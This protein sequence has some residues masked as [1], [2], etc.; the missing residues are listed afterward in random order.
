M[1]TYY[2]IYKITNIK[3]NKFYIGAHRTTDINDKYM[4]SGVYLKQAQKKYG[5]ENFKKEIL[6]VFD[7]EHDMFNKE[8]E[9]VNLHE[10]SYNLMNGGQG[11]WTYARSKI[12]SDSY[13]KISATMLTDEYRNKTESH[14]KK[15]SE[16]L[17]AAPLMANSEI[18]NKV[19]KA[20]TEKMNDPEWIVTTGQK[21]SSAIAKSVKLLHADGRYK[22]RDKKLSS[23]RTGMKQATLNNKKIW[24]KEDD[25]RI[26]KD[27]FRYGW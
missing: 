14:R 21:R 7:N 26:N 16:R 12:T 2:L 4:G 6:C 3:T 5:I 17:R 1:K 11:G 19:S 23:A 18:R 24:I 25:P 15:S 27:G 8:A 13:K 20:I 9:L 22:E 10:N